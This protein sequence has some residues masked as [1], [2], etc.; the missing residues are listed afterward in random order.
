VV[1]AVLQ[2]TTDARYR[3][4]PP[5]RL[6]NHQAGQHI[7][8]QIECEARTSCKCCSIPRTKASTKSTR[9]CSAHN[10]ENSEIPDKSLTGLLSNKQKSA[11][12]S[13]RP[14][15][16]YP[17]APGRALYLSITP[18]PTPPNKSPP[19][20]ELGK[21]CNRTRSC[22]LMQ[23]HNRNRRVYQNWP[24]QGAHKS[25]G[26]KPNTPSQPTTYVETSCC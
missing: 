15:P 13:L 4:L 21:H 12:F 17:N 3:G 14:P 2:G 23:D 16:K 10:S 6:R 20:T 1:P 25:A 24:E 9:A 7:C 19:A 11:W 26:C 8:P 5:P 18:A 22:Q